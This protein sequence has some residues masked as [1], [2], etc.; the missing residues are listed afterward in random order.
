M[1]RLIL[2]SSV[3]LAFGCTV[4]CS[5][6]TTP[7]VVQVPIGQAALVYADVH[8]L[9]ILSVSHVTDW[10]KG[11]KLSEANC[12]YLE[13]KNEQ[14]NKVDAEI[15]KGILSAKGEIDWEKVMEYVE[16][17][18]GILVKVGKAAL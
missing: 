16:I 7:P 13:T 15:R 14:A 9:H 18:T 17:I 6:V 12:T 3:L 8:A 2:C 5:T 10:C 1:R 11:K 4:G